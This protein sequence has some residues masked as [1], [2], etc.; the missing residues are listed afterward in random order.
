MIGSLA[1]GRGNIEA[2]LLFTFYYHST[3]LSAPDVQASS[4]LQSENCVG[5][6]PGLIPTCIGSQRKCRAS[7]TFQI[8][9]DLPG[10]RSVCCLS[11][12]HQELN[13]RTFQIRSKRS[14]RKVILVTVLSDNV[15]SD[16]PVVESSNRKLGIS[17]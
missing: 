13:H 17:F 1:P 4:T 12:S 16:A 6:S 15:E 11:T 10:S 9:C 2:G 5:D 14:V 7:H 8:S 3:I